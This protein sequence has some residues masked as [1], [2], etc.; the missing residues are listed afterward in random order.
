MKLRRENG[1][2]QYYQRTSTVYSQFF[3]RT[4][5]ASFSNELDGA[6]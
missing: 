4:P 6:R 2:Q 1:E 5:G 3:N